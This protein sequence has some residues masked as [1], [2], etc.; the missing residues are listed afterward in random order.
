MSLVCNYLKKWKLKISI[1]KTVSSVFHIKN[2][3]AK[4]PLKVCMDQGTTLKFEPTPK[5]LGVRL[6]RSLTF[7][8]HINELK[9]K[10]SARIAL[11]KRLASTNWGASFKVLRTSTIAL[12]YAPAEYCVPTWCRSTHAHIMDVPLN[13]AMR[14]ITGCIRSTPT[15]YLPFLAGISPPEFRRKA[16]CYKLYKK[17][18]APDHLLHQTLYVKAVRHVYLS[19]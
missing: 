5:Y 2:H 13:E 12:A 8:K 15:S 11:L 3:L 19:I 6:D 1:D 7:N 10:V 9:C 14:V 18:N 16:I 4:L 17:A